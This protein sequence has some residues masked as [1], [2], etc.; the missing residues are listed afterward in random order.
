[1]VSRSKYKA[2]PTVIDGIRF[3]SKKEGNRY[4]ELK[5]ME[6][7]NLI[8]DLKLQQPIKCVVNGIQVCKYVSDFSYYDREKNAIIFEDAKG[9]KTPIYNLKKKLVLACTG[10]VITEV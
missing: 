2:Q 3:A 8:S 1:M 10:I 4:T 6:R 7:G 9:Y 5:M